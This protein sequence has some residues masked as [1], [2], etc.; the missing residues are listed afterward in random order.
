MKTPQSSFEALSPDYKPTKTFTQLWEEAGRP[1]NGL[2]E[3]ALHEQEMEA[4]GR[5]TAAPA[6]K[7]PEGQAHEERGQ[8]IA[9]AVVENLNRKTRDK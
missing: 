3:L 5:S 8:R 9:Q 2:R 1:S 7:S 6:A 4:Q